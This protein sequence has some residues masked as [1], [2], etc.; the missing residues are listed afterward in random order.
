[1]IGGAREYIAFINDPVEGSSFEF[2]LACFDCLN[3]K[4][5]VPALLAATRSG[6]ADM[7]GVFD[8]LRDRLIAHSS[9]A[10]REL[11][12]D[13]GVST[14]TLAN[15]QAASVLLDR[16][17]RQDLNDLFQAHSY[18]A[19]QSHLLTPVPSAYRA[20]FAA[21]VSEGRRPKRAAELLNGSGT[22]ANKYDK[23]TI[24]RARKAY[25]RHLARW[26]LSVDPKCSPLDLAN[27]HMTVDVSWLMASMVIHDAALRRREFIGLRGRALAGAI[28]QQCGLS[29]TIVKQI[30]RRDRDLGVPLETLLCL[31]LLECAVPIA[32]ASAPGGARNAA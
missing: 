17:V 15:K 18:A 3:A 28:D 4:E 22:R 14:N 12:A 21:Y 32:N 31:S 19:S 8:V 29:G 5:H 11:I 30:V 23:D 20:A 9:Q 7:C 27:A 10:A 26:L 13:A 16:L 25:S 2:V 24:G 6:A 1:M